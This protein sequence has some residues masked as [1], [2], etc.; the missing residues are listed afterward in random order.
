MSGSSRMDYQALYICYIG[1]QG[2][3]LQVINKLVS[4]LLATLYVKGKR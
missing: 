3:N 2:E 1:Q 4:F